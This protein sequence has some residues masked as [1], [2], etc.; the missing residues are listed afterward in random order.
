MTDSAKKKEK[1][2]KI[3]NVLAAEFVAVPPLAKCL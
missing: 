2:K 3:V 1:E